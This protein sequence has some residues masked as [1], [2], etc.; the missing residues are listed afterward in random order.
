VFIT[1][2]EDPSYDELMAHEA[3][4]AVQAQNQVLA[5]FFAGADLL[6]HDAQYT[7]EEYLD[8]KVGWGHTPIEHAIASARD[9]GV[10][11]LA[12]FHHDPDRSDEQLDK[13]GKKYCSSSG[14]DGTQIFFARE[15]M[16]IDL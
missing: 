8:G 3:D 10:K 9:A 11:R 15:G 7:N 12:L 4:L 6:V 2:P 13:L 14:A 5:D 1:D 16:E